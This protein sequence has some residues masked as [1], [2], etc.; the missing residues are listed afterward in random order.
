MEFE[1]K[2]K[3]DEEPLSRS[4]RFVLYFNIKSS[5]IEESQ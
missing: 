5:T 2:E 3:R 4:P 1:I